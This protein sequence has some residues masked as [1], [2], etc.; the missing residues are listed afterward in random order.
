MQVFNTL[1]RELQTLVPRDPGRIGIYLCGPT[2]QAAPHIGHG[3]GPVVFD[4]LRR[5]LTW[6]G[7]EVNFVSNVTD[8]NDTIFEQAEQRGIAWTDLVTESS[9]QFIDAYR[10]LG[11]K[12]PDVRPTVTE[13]MDEIVALIQQLVDKGAAYEAGGD[14]YFRVRSFEDYGKLSG[15]RIDELISGARIEAGEHKEDPLDF[16]LWKAVKRGEASWPSP[17]GDGRPG[18]HIECSAMARTYL[19][20]GF[21]IH[22]GGIDL[23]FPH[24]E[25]EVAQSEAATGVPF[26]RYWIHNG[27]I[28]LAGEKMSKSVGNVV[29][30]AQMLDEHPP[31]AIRLFYL[32]SHY[33]KP[34]DYTTEVM[35]DAEASLERLWAFRRRVGRPVTAEPDPAAIADFRS[36]MDDDLDTAGALAVLFD[37]VRRGNTALDGGEIP[38]AQVA[39]F[40]AIMEVLGL[41]EPV[42]DLT[43]L[44]AELRSLAEEMGVEEDGDLIGR[45]IE[46]R[47]EARLERDYSTSDRIRDALGALGIVLEDAAD[48]TRWHRQ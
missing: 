24:H 18:W 8:V 41:V 21:D 36:A 28:N 26:C 9:S 19:G 10:R 42:A 31:L 43:D 38:E 16:A 3:R 14:V 32:R 11:V 37:L 44:E 30:L 22:G 47:Q 29:D 5:Y 12:D 27:F 35:Q 45:L 34:V 20:D 4:V 48:G 39:A 1:G 6:L 7:F 25:N 17:W 23:V 40:D 2:V 33:R 46:R 15:R 13:H